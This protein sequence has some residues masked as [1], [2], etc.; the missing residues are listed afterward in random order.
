MKMTELE[1]PKVLDEDKWEELSE[2]S[3]E[4]AVKGYEDLKDATI[5]DLFP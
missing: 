3:K 1:K 4:K 5:R 2:E